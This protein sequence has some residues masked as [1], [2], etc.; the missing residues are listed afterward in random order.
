MCRAL[1][2]IVRLEA[3]VARMASNAAEHG[4]NATMPVASQEIN[5]Q[6]VR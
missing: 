5:E 1:A 2:K 4:S 6:Q 3:E